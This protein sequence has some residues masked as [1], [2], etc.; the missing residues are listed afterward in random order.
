MLTFRV[1]LQDVEAVLKSK[2]N[3][4]GGSGSGSGGGARRG[5]VRE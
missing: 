5:K 2:G 3:K 1:Y 4:T